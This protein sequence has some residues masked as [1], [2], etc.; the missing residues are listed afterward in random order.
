MTCPHGSCIET[1]ELKKPTKLGYKCYGCGGCNKTFNNRTN[2][3]LPRVPTDIVLLVV[4][5]R[6]RYKLTLR[7]S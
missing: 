6:L 5:W 1:E 4:L 7:D 2:T 3:L